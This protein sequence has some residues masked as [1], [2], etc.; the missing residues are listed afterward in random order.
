M[1]YDDPDDTC[2]PCDDGDIW[3]DCDDEIDCT[4]DHCNAFGQCVYTPNDD[5]CYEVPDLFCNGPE[6]CNPA[7]PDPELPVS[8][9]GHG[10]RP[11]PPEVCDEENDVCYGCDA[12]VVAAVGARYISI[13]PQQAS[14]TTV[15]FLVSYCDGAVS[16]Y[17]GD[18]IDNWS[19][20]GDAPLAT[21]GFLVDDPAD[22]ESREV[23]GD[24]GQWGDIIYV[25]GED[26]IPSLQ[27]K[28][29]GGQ[30]P[31]PAWCSLYEVRAECVGSPPSDPVP[32][33]YVDKDGHVIPGTWDW[34]DN[35]P[36][37]DHVVGLDDVLVQIN[38]YQGKWT[39][40]ETTTI[41]PNMDM[42]MASGAAA[43]CEPDQ[44]IGLNDIVL[45]ISAFQ[46]KT[47]PDT[48]CPDP[49]GP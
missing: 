41:K 47:W 34:G 35:A 31:D 37:P 38:A 10:S 36:P 23:G 12:P 49:C 17:V 1:H 44:V 14:G 16:K 8:G 33:T 46:G 18:V 5:L 25:T 3:P 29:S 26:L 28:W 43:L 27:C 13:V 6:I 42:A 9:C 40:Q 32:A 2:I 48:F 45:T 24:V 11:C 7:D 22:A 20:G 15:A 30:P 39:Y 4:D 21:L 19:P